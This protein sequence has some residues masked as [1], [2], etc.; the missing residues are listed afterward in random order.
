MSLCETR[1]TPVRHTLNHNLL[2]SVTRLTDVARIDVE[3]R[4]CPLS[5]TPVS[6]QNNGRG[7]RSPPVPWGRS[8]NLPCTNASAGRLR[9]SL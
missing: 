3:L 1:R 6:F 4:R 7:R 2:S 5:A 8:S 9:G